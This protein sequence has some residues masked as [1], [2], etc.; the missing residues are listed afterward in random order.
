MVGVADP[1]PILDVG[2]A[3]LNEG[4]GPNVLEDEDEDDVV[5]EEAPP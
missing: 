4:Y 2:V 1:R 3:R 5:V